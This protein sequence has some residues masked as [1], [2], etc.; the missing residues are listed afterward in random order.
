MD[1]IERYRHAVAM[2]SRAQE[3]LRTAVQHCDTYQAIDQVEHWKNEVT[4][5]HAALPWYHSNMIDEY[6]AVKVFSKAFL[7]LV[8]LVPLTLAI[9]AMIV[10]W[11]T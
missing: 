9:S 6:E 7:L 11:A 2:L 8:F 3:Y 4:L 10:Y 1:A 5:A